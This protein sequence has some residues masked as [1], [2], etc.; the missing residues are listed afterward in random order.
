MITADF[1]HDG[2]QDII[3]SDQGDGSIS[4]LLG[5]GDGTLCKVQQATTLL[6]IP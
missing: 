4:I 1:N 3:N 5:N 6:A 2:K